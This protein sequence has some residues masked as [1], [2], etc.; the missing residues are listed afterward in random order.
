RR[1]EIGQLASDFDRMA[2]RLQVLIVSERRLL[3]DISHEL[4]GP[5]ARLKF[6]VKLARDSKD[7]RDSLQRIDKDID[8]LGSLVSDL[9]EITALEGDPTHQNRALINSRAIAEE[10]VQ[11]CALDATA[12]GCEV[13][14]K[15]HGDT[16]LL[17]NAELLRRAIENVLRNAIRYAPA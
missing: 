9:L 12:Q 11:D 2:D 6:A 8:R 14:L 4:R 5:L 3:E 7:P 10:V 15:I 16:Q 1:D 17:G 13:A